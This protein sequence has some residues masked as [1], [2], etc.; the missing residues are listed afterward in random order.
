MSGAPG[1]LPRVPR[2]ASFPPIA[3]ADARVLILGSM[4]GVR[5]LEAGQY[6]AHPHNGFWPI[7]CAFVGLD[8]S[9]GYAARTSAL[10]RHGI[11][12]WDVLRS[13]ERPGSLDAAIVRRGAVVNDFAGFLARHARIATVLCNGGTA[14][15]LFVKFGLPQ[16]GGERRPEIV[17]LPSTSP[18]HAS[19]RLGAKQRV[20]H[21]ALARALNGV[22]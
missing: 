22:R 20:W 14:H 11:A 10:R 15:D 16:L 8:P 12:L 5:S 9:A 21:D 4:P 18:A 3:R 6:Y 1:N 19:L 7:A 2:V 17:R 13:C